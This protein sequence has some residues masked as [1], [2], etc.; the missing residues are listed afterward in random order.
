MLEKFR[1]I[2][3]VFFTCI[4]YI[5]AI[6]KRIKTDPRL[7]QIIKKILLKNYRFFLH[8]HTYPVKSDF[9]FES[10]SLINIS[11]KWALD[12][13]SEISRH[14]SAPPSTTAPHIFQSGRGVFDSL[15]DSNSCTIS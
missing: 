5:I 9:E 2:C 1:K 15:L 6:L 13:L 12:L 11:N 3:G 4:I 14:L 10:S 8:S 7:V